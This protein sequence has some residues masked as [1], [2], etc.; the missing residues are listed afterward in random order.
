MQAPA[1]PL[2]WITHTTSLPR[3]RPAS[4][5]GAGPGLRSASRIPR[6]RGLCRPVLS[7]RP[8]I[9]AISRDGGNPWYLVSDET[10]ESWRELRGARANRTGSDLWS[11]EMDG[12]ECPPR[13]GSRRRAGTGGL[14]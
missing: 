1:K 8:R 2:V 12:Q 4:P 13:A 9:A 3:D 7:G 6:L 10:R 11:F 5:Y 14:W